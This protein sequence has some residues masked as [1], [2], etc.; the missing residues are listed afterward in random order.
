MKSLTCCICGRNAY[1][2]QWWNRD[3]GYGLCLDCAAKWI[4]K[5]EITEFKRSYGE[6]G[7]HWGADNPALAKTIVEATNRAPGPLY[8][9]VP[10]DTISYGGRG[11]PPTR[12]E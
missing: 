10:R 9:G 6:P 8:D 5:S 11:D 7:R 2:K 4:K 1:G 12:V 3:K